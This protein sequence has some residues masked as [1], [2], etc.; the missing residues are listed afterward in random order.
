MSRPA[1]IATA[2]ALSFA[3]RRRAGSLGGAG[4]R[5]YRRRARRAA[6]SHAARRPGPGPA[7]RESRR[8]YTEHKCSQF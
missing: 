2:L 7:A 3:P 5:Q 4:R 1:F 6:A 8:R